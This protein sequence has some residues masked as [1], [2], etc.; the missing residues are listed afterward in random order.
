M[1]IKKSQKVA[2]RRTL[3]N[4]A[5]KSLMKTKLKNANKQINED[6]SAPNTLV[7]L[8]TALRTLDVSVHKGVV[9]K[10]SAARKKSKITK[11]YN[12][13]LVEKE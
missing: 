8:R 9:H 7:V 13:R 2:I 4:R 12:S 5:A 1:P 11:L 3:R 6:V 10:N